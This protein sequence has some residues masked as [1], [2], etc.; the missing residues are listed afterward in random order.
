MAFNV[1]DGFLTSS[2]R[3]KSRNEG[4]ARNTKII[5]GTIVQ[6]VSIC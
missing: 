4:S 5:A 6:I 1:N 3:Y 2:V